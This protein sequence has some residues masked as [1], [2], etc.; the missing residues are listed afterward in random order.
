MLEKEQLE[1]LYSSGLSMQEIADKEKLSYPSVRYWMQQLGIQRRSWSDATYAKRNLDGDP[2]SIKELRSVDDLKLFHTAIGLYLGEG[3]KK[4]KHHVNIANTNPY[5]LKIFLRF[6]REIC[7]A[8]ECKISA[9]LNIFNDV[10]LKKAISYWIGEV[11]IRREQLRTITVRE[12]RG[13]SYK[14]KS[15]YGTL[16]IYFSNIKLK[17]IIIDWCEEVVIV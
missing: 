17:K 7:G 16:S 5:I 4:S 13:G 10:D 3:D 1:E 2:F 8:N 15:E 11:G 12:S 14:N 9:A 6:L